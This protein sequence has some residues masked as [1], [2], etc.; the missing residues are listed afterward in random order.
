MPKV[1]SQD[2]NLLFPH[3]LQCWTSF[4]VLICYPYMLFDEYFCP[5]FNWVVFILL[6]FVDFN[7]FWM[8]SFIRYVICEQ[9]LSVCSLSIYSL[10]SV[11]WRAKFINLDEV[12]FINYF[13][14]WA[15]SLV[16]NKSLHSLNSTAFYY[17]W[18]IHLGFYI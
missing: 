5:F 11:F 8:Q 15:F 14:G 13:M 9:F 2:F 12:K 6:N 7:I 1:V 10:N 4:Y 3:D 16:C 18:C 17:R